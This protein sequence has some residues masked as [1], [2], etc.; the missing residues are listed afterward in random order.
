[1]TALLKSAVAMRRLSTMIL[2]AFG[3]VAILIAAV[4]LYGVVSHNVTERTREIGVRMALGAGSSRILYLFIRQGLT[5][6]VIGTLVGLAGALGLSRWLRTLLF[7]VEPTD[8]TTLAAAGIL[9]LIVAAVACYVPA[10][11]ATQVDPLVALKAE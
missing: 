2:A 4:G 3:A 5:V 1:M 11:R 8:P 7:G 9:L 6:A 10:R